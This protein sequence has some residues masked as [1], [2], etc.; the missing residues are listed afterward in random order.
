MF[1]LET[2]SGNVYRYTYS[3]PTFPTRS[4]AVNFINSK[5]LKNVRP[6]EYNKDVPNDYNNGTTTK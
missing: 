6:K 4:L 1:Y 3:T 5:G 2:E